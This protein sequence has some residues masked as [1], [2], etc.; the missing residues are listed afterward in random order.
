MY[1][2]GVAVE[3]EYIWERWFGLI[4]SY[5][6]TRWFSYAPKNKVQMGIPR[7]VFS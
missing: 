7:D 1:M 4:G 3:Y 5:G 6:I 2:P